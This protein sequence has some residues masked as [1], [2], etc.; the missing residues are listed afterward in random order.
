MIL[1]PIFEE[2]IRIYNAKRLWVFR[3]KPSKH[4]TVFSTETVNIKKMAKLKIM[5]K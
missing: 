2:Q 4:L 1:L 5:G 3:E